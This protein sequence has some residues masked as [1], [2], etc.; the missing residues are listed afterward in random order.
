MKVAACAPKNIC[1]AVLTIA[2]LSFAPLGAQA[3]VPIDDA[4][5]SSPEPKVTDFGQRLTDSSV[6]SILKVNLKLI[7]ELTNIPLII[8]TRATFR[9]QLSN[10]NVRNYNTMTAAQSTLDLAIASRV[11]DVISTIKTQSDSKSANFEEYV[12]GFT[13]TYSDQSSVAA[14]LNSIKA[15]LPPA[16]FGVSVI[17]NELSSFKTK[18]LDQDK[19][20]NK[21]SRKIA[22]A[23]EHLKNGSPLPPQLAS[24]SKLE[25]EIFLVE[26]ITRDVNRGDLN[27]LTAAKNENFNALINAYRTGKVRSFLVTGATFPAMSTIFST[28]KGPIPLKFSYSIDDP[29]GNGKS[30]FITRSGEIFYTTPLDD[31]GLSKLSPQKVLMLPEYTQVITSM[32]VAKRNNVW[33]GIDSKP[34][35]MCA[36]GVCVGASQ[37][38]AISTA[39]PKQLPYAPSDAEYIGSPLDPIVKKHQD[40]ERAA[41]RLRDIRRQANPIYKQ[42]N[43]MLSAHKVLQRLV[44]SNQSQDKKIHAMK[45]LL[46]ALNKCKSCN[47][48]DFRNIKALLKTDALQVTGFNKKLL[49]KAAQAAQKLE[50]R[51]FSN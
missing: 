50:D 34:I 36:D 48:Q 18:L 26:S 31:M 2:L 6:K 32:P 22:S 20:D 46:K 8:Q 35:A 25:W 37:K 4:F 13:R 49:D 44:T 29:T 1:S 3:A 38:N 23:I 24:M 21:M 7:Q 10:F 30:S 12:S 14:K 16:S 9:R 28:V 47:Q 5:A 40:E 33:W 27:L 43:K 51:R 42:I 15:H 39:A 41:T 45:G 11:N 17:D 19:S